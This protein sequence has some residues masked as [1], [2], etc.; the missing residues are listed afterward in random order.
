MRFSVAPLLMHSPDIPASVR[1]QLRAAYQ[2]D[3]ERRDEHLAAAAR[4][5]H[6][7]LA[8]ECG[9]ARELVGLPPGGC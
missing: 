3:Q 7:E 2:D 6:E 4:L 1:D 5:I 8:L 9:D